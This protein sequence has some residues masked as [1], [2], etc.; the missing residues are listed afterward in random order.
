MIHFFLI[1][2][3]RFQFNQ[4]QNSRFK[5]Q[6]TSSSEWKSISKILKRGQPRRVYFNFRKFLL[7]I[8]QS[9]NSSRESG[10]LWP[11]IP[12][13]IARWNPKWRLYCLKRWLRLKILAQFFLQGIL[14]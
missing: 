4:T 3:A 9:E 11:V 12:S 1:K 13:I 10:P 14:L 8:Q 6:E 2:K 7:G 5:F